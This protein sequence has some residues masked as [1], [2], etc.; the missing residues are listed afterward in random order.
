M[1]VNADPIPRPEP[2][3][4]SVYRRVVRLMTDGELEPG[5]TLTEAGLSK[6]LGVSRT[7]VREA[8]LQLEAEGVLQSTPARGFTVRELTAT[9]ATELFPILAALEALA[10]RQARPTPDLRTLRKLDA[11]LTAAEDPVT[12]WRLDTAFH[13]TMVER[14]RNASLRALITRLRVTLSRYEIEYMRRAGGAQHTGG[15]RHAAIVDALAHRDLDGAADAI[16]RNWQ[17][18]LDAVRTWLAA[19]TA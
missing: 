12:R 4:A 11:E 15:N 18:S 5:Q 10:V 7:P 8:L 16:A 3:R 6:A 13:E 14:C 2:L 19:G 17:Q 9:E 1:A